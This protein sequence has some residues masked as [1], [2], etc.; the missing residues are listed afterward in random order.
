ML[1]AF[2]KCE[3]TAIARIS[4]INLYRYQ[5]LLNNL[6]VHILASYLYFISV[7][8]NDRTKHHNVSYFYF[9]TTK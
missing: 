1:K 5:P 7:L 8:Y 6:K 2:I 4:T 9:K 3:I